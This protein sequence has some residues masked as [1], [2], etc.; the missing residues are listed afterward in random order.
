MGF[1]P[2]YGLTHPDGNPILGCMDR[3]SDSR[4]TE[5]F[6][7]G[8]AGAVVDFLSFAAEKGNLNT[9]TANSLKVALREVLAAT[10][11]SD[12]A[13]MNLSDIDKDDHVHRFHTLRAMRYK[14]ETLDTYGKRF[15][16]AIE[17]YEAFRRDPAGWRPPRRERRARTGASAKATTLQV[18]QQDGATGS[19][20]T[21]SGVATSGAR[22]PLIPYPFPLRKGVLA[23]V[24]LPANLSRRE[25]ERLASFI[26]SLA[27]DPGE[28]QT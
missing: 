2:V 3:N 20:P 11:G 13:S 10:S 22:A 5:V 26:Q 6:E 21:E 24:Q 27:V 4:S 12:W 25:A 15:V 8:S 7:P 23:T 19:G 28:D 18:A 16:S 9:S 1:H 17:M 14:P